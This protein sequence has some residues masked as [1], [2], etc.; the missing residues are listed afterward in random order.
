MSDNKTPVDRAIELFVYAPIGFAL[1]ARSLLP[2]LVERGRQQLT[3]QVTMARVVGQFAVQ[4]GQAEAGKRVGAVRRQAE[5]ALGDL[6]LLGPN[7]APP[8]GRGAGGA[9]GDGGDGRPAAEPAAERVA[10][11]AATDGTAATAAATARSGGAAGEPPPPAEAPAAPRS[12]PDAGHLAIPDYD[13]LSA[14]QVV[15]RLAGLSPE[16]LEAVRAYESETRGRKTILNRVAQLQ[17]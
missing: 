17:G 5:A 2:Q 16:E 10:G 6:G 1:E 13:S 7:G 9:G 4:Q 14:S 15:P 3:G 8:P 12:A 11:T